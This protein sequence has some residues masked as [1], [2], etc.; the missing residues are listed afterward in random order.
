ML[1]SIISI[2]KTDVMISWLAPDD[3][4]SH[5]TA[6][7]IYFIDNTLSIPAYTEY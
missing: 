6:Y 3:S 5:I 1:P 7:H 4:G 2:D